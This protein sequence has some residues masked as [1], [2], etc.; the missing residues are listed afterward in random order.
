MQKEIAVI[1][2]P[3]PELTYAGLS[4]QAKTK[5]EYDNAV[6]RKHCR[7]IAEEIADQIQEYTRRGIETKIV[8]GVDG[9]PSCGVNKASER[10][11][12][13][14]ASAHDKEGVAGILIEELQLAFKK[15]KISVPFHGITY[16]SLPE[17]LAK[18]DKLLEG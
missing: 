15:R 11:I 18:I 6:F 2:M 5:D 10:I 13:E 12:R 7:K 14:S 8:L 1:Q 16:E 9:S 17:D 4:R 3:C